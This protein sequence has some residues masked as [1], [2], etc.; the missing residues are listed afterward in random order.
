MS[1]STEQAPNHPPD[2]P[3]RRASGLG[4]VCVAVIVMLIVSASL[5]WLARD[6]SSASA[7]QKQATP[8][9]TT[10][11]TL[12]PT[13]TTT[14][15]MALFYDTFANNFHG[16]SLNSNGGYFRILT[17]NSLILADTNPNSTLVEP[18][19]TLTNLDN[20][21]VSADFTINQGDAHDNIGFYLRGDSTL[22]HDYRIDINGNNTLDVARE[23][24]D[25]NQAGQSAM[26]VQPAYSSYLHPLGKPN[27]LTV[28]MIG[29]QITV[30]INK[31]VVM[32]ATDNSY[33][34]GQ[35]TLFARHGVTSSGVTVSFTRV[36]IDHLTSQFMTPVP[37]LTLTA[38][39][40]VTT[41]EP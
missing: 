18:V 32:T 37:T 25:A 26:S 9:P 29:S 7:N 22:F 2:L 21:V 33:T 17:N 38:T 10:M 5:F 35:I 24:L 23:Y 3:R 13:I 12:G 15:L 31:I 19:P 11:P 41:G 4:L 36:E 34:N 14:P 28:F 40:S 8:T 39:P 6:R 20:Y 27:T 16:W 30:E 1:S